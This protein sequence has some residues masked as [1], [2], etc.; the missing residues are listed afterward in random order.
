MEIISLDLNRP[1]HQ[2]AENPTIPL[3]LIEHL[4]F[5]IRGI[6]LHAI[7]SDPEQLALLNRRLGEI[8]Q[9]LSSESSAD[10][11]LAAIGKTL[12]LTQEYNGQATLLFKGQVEELREMLAAMVATTEFIVSSSAIS[13]K[14][15][16]FM[17]SQ[18]QKASSLEDLRQLKTFAAA[19]LTLVRRES[20]RLQ[21]ETHARIDALKNHV[22]RLSVR[23][24]AAAI[25]E[26]LDQTTGLPGRAAAEQSIE[27]KIAAGK[28]FV[29]AQY[30]MTE[31]AAI[32]D[33]FGCLVGEEVMVTCAHMLAK[34]LSG[35]ALFRWSGPA[36]VAIFDPSLGV[37]DA[38]IRAR[39]AGAQKL[40]RDVDV[41]GRT[42]LI[43]VSPKCQVQQIS[44]LTE[45]GTI[46]NAMDSFMVA[47]V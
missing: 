17:E 3:T 39:Q 33:R 16:G 4:Q 36:F 23:L 11:L 45:P 29:A 5:L 46:F 41:D 8:A 18:L 35:A 28:S 43:V 9:S 44:P 10:E 30:M 22:T 38:E 47:V 2:P 42:L 1:H 19:C 27:D 6:A 21:E 37:A 31:M 24:K 12:R 15:L 20:T 7:E 14:Q 13:V 25:E 34:K 32:N 40:E 26:S